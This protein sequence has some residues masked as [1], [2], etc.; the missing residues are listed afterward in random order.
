MA[1]VILPRTNIVRGFNPGRPPAPQQPVRLDAPPLS[2]EHCERILLLEDE[3]QTNFILREYL[4]SLGY[5]VVA[6]AN[7][8]DGLREVIQSDFELVICDMMMP[9]LPGDMFYLAVQKTRPQLCNR[10]VFITG[11]QQNATVDAF[12]AKTHSAILVKPFRLQQLEA[13]LE[14]ILSRFPKK[15]HP[16][17]QSDSASDR[18]ETPLKNIPL[19]E[20]PQTKESSS[21]MSKAFRM[22]GDF[23]RHGSSTAAKKSPAP[24]R[25]P[26]APAISALTPLPRETPQQ[27]PSVT[28]RIAHLANT[29]IV[30]SARTIPF[31]G[32][33]PA[34]DT[35]AT[36]RVTR[37]IAPPPSAQKSTS[38]TNGS[39][40][41]NPKISQP[42][43]NDSATKPPVTTRVSRLIRNP[44]DA[45][46]TKGL[47]R[48]AQETPATPS[49]LAPVKPKGLLRGPDESTVKTS[50]KIA[51]EPS[52]TIQPRPL[53]PLGQ[54]AAT[55][56][57]IISPK[58]VAKTPAAK[59]AQVKTTKAAS[60]PAA[61]SPLRFDSKKGSAKPVPAKSAPAKRSKKNVF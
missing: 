33:K 9:K 47:L 18:T 59:P 4:Q 20:E 60:V 41:L 52:Q 23:M 55:P 26:S 43:Q 54:S 21:I 24:D 29:P 50:R 45:A 57:K 37:R 8:V 58:T 61:K 31:P 27:T 49:G 17:Q 42:P 2:Q 25:P 38:S 36:I 6:V 16:L 51:P 30:E 22:V 13:T 39:A 3:A 56:L 32:A 5:Q 19:E 35:S 53:S 7:G 48:G 46:K 14:T 40:P 12:I 34:V 44:Q 15:L 28:R 10:F 11:H 1:K